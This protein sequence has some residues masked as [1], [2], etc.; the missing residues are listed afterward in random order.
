MAALTETVHAGAFVVSD[1][2]TLSWDTGIAGATLV[3]GQVVKVTGGKYVSYNGSGTVVGI[4]RNDC[5]LNDP[6]ALMARL[7]EVFGDSLTSTE[8]TSGEI[9]TGATTG[10]AAL[11]I[12]VR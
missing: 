12:I 8:Q 11:N 1:L 2:G 7:G 4:V 6:V 5:V 3:A 9:S 10:L